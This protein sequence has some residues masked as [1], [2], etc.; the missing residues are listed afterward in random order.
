MG[1]FNSLNK[2]GIDWGVDTEK[3][4]YIR[5]EEMKDAGNIV[6]KGVFI[7]KKG[8]FDPHPVA[9]IENGLL[10]L[11]AHQTENVQTILESPEM[12]EAVKAGKCAVK[13]VPY[14]AKKYNK[15]CFTV[16]WVDVE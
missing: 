2:G 13:V 8:N 9:I 15:D 10:D 5:L 16:D 3:M 7:N 1:M 12:V 14:T 4:Q 11:P 6:I